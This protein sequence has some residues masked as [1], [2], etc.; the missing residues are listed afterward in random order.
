MTYYKEIK[1]AGL[2]VTL[3]YCYAVEQHIFNPQKSYGYKSC[4]TSEDFCRDLEK[5]YTEKVIPAAQK[6]LCAAI[7]T[8]V[9]DVEDEINGLLT[10]DRKVEKLDAARMIPVAEALQRMIEGGN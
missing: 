3:C 1:I 9:S 10:Y 7:Y 8:Q 2:S 5:L 6:G 4:K